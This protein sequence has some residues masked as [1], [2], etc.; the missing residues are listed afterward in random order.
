MVMRG[1]AVHIGYGKQTKG[2]AMKLYK[3]SDLSVING[4]LVNSDNEVV[5]PVGNVI[6]QA[7][8]LETLLQK[9]EYINA[10]PKATPMPSLDGFVRKSIKD[11]LRG[12]M[13]FEV[14]TPV[15]DVEI[16]KTMAMMDEIDD[17]DS[18]HKANEVIKEF[19]NLVAFT[20]SE[21]VAS[22]CDDTMVVCDTPTLGSILDLTKDDVVN[23]V[24]KICG[25]EPCGIDNDKVSC[26]CDDIDEMVNILDK[27]LKEEEENH[28]DSEDDEE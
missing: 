21:Y 23:A 28:S 16:A 2:N 24:A 26:I 10:Q 3:K 25:L 13:T 18:V 8:F 17:I 12:S 7:N 27:M 4:M 20:E 19:E 15:L 1:H 5:I 11:D 9:T 14:S 6:E 22:Q